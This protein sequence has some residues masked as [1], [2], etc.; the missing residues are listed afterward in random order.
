MKKKFFASVGKRK[1]SVARVYLDEVG[2]G[3]ITINHLSLEDYFK[4][5]TSRMMVEQ[6]LHLTQT[7]GKVNIRVNV[8]GGGL[9]GQAGAIRHGITRSLLLMNPELR[10]VLKSAGLITRDDR[11]K[12]RKKYGLRSARARFQF[13]KR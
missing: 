5:P 12:E 6:A 1:T 4:R 7:I 2:T 11:V 10:G 8:L 9:S 3:Q 13:S